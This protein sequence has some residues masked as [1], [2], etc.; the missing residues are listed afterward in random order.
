M[1]IV[2]ATPP[3]GLPDQLIVVDREIAQRHPA[4]A[5]YLRVQVEKGTQH[6]DLDGA[7]TPLD[8]G[9]LAREKGTEP[10]H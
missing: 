10:P 4:K 7:V 6:V 1:H 2:N 5:F 3:A 8:A 9:R